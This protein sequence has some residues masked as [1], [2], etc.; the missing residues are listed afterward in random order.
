MAAP[1]EITIND[2]SGTWVMQ[3]VGWFMRK[4]IALSTITLSIKQYV[5]DGGVTHIDIE[6]T[7]TGGIKTTELRTLDWQVRDHEDRVFGK[8]DAQARWVKLADVD[9]DAF[10]KTGWDDLEGEHV[11]GYVES[12]TNGWTADQIWGFEYV[13]EKRYHVRHAVVRKGDDWKQ[14]RLVYDYLGK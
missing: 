5:D 9:D 11:Q 4:A 7:A 13:H 2:L 12:K 8:V 14:A 10:L 6:Q 1:P 3:G